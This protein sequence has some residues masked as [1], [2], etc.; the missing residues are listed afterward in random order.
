[1]T[2]DAAAS[3]GPVVPAWAAVL[4]AGSSP[5]AGWTA[6][7][8]R[9]HSR[10][11]ADAPGH[12]V[13]SLTT[14]QLLDLLPAALRALAEKGDVRR[15]RAGALIINEGDRTDTLFILL[16]GRMRA[17]SV[18]ANDREITFCID[19]AGEYFG[20]MSLDGGPRSCSVVALEPSVCAVVSRDTVLRHVSEYP[21]FAITLIERVIR[22]ARF[23]TESA[24]SMAL[25][26]VYGRMARLF[27]ELAT[28]QSDGTRV[29]AER[30]TQQETANRVGASREMV[31]RVMKDL[32]R[33]GYV[34][35]T[36]Q[37]I[38]LLRTLPAH[39]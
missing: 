3:N 2:G 29:V 16:L 22:R 20:E 26:D 19:G 15:Y 13:P 1:M 34:E 32:E 18:G 35:V 37:Q 28:L 30:L 17:F 38:T 9:P 33:G 39:W 10:P 12:V 7:V 25:F 24:R 11:G 31:S 21:E 14:A 36:R 27:N 4:Q 23:A 5:P 6:R 8:R